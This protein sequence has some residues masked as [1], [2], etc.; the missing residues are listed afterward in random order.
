MRNKAEGGSP[1]GLLERSAEHTE[2]AVFVA[3]AYRLGAFGWLSGPTFQKNGTP[4]VGLL[5]QRLA[6]EWVQNYAHLFGGDAKRVTVLGESAGAGSILHH[7]TAYGGAKGPG[8]LPFQQAVTQSASIHNPTQSKLL[9]EQVFQ[10]FLDAAGVGTLDEA[11]QLPSET[12]QLANK[13]I[14]YSAAFGLYIF[15]KL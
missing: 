9:E 6:L 3:I 11:R 10:S 13:K 4:N 7:I 5:D 12:L 8:Q 2:G 1:I 15:R 14:I